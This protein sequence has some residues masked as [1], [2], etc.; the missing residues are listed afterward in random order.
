MMDGL[1]PL[2][3]NL[4][5]PSPKVKK[6]LRMNP[7]KIYITPQDQ[8]VKFPKLVTLM[9]LRITLKTNLARSPQKKKIPTISVQT[10]LFRN[11]LS[12]KSPRI[13]VQSK[14]SRNQFLKKIPRTT[15]QSKMSR[16]QLSKMILRITVQL[17][18]LRNPL[19]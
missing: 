13:T 7:S 1:L 14:T 2:K 10:K 17:K 3:I 12:K 19:S 16:N 9:N 11:P 8:Q 4:K 18:S 5:N 6:T 15:L